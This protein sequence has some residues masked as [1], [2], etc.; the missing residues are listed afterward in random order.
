MPPERTLVDDRLLEA[1]HP[2]PGRG[3]EML[4]VKAEAG[5]QNLVHRS[6]VSLDAAVAPQNDLNSRTR[7]GKP[8]DHVE[9]AQL[10][11]TRGYFEIRQV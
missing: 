6:D 4:R 10:S 5:V 8:L 9:L 11:E 3:V 2:A 7:Q 1:L